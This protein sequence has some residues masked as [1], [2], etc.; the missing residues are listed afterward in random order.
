[1]IDLDISDAQKQVSHAQF[2]LEGIIAAM[3]S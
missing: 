2:F 3:V 1:M